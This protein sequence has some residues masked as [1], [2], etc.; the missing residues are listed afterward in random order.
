MPCRGGLSAIRAYY[1]IYQEAQFALE[2]V[3]FVRTEWTYG[4]LQAILLQKVFSFAL[5]SI[6][7]VCMRSPSLS[8]F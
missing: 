7:D 3:G 4:G 2:A 8:P 6:T 5:Q 1:A